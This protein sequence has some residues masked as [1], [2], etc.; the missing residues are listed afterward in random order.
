[1]IT[2]RSNLL[3]FII[4]IIIFNLHYIL[5]LNFKTLYLTIKNNDI[6]LLKSRDL[7]FRSIFKNEKQ[8]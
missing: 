3:F 6:Y 5:P 2:Q 7:C 8:I 4:T 1:M